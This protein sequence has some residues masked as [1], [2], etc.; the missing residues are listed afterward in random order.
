MKPKKQERDR[1]HMYDD[2]DTKKTDEENAAE[3]EVFMTNIAHTILQE[4]E[5]PEKIKT[6]ILLAMQSQIQ[7]RF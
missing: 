3:L 1:F 5:N 2:A 7:Q 6:D 4:S